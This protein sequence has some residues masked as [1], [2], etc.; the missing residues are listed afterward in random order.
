[1]PG[2]DHKRQRFFHRYRYGLSHLRQHRDGIRHGHRR[3]KAGSK[4]TS[5]RSRRI[6]K[7]QALILTGSALSLIVL[8]IGLSAW[9]SLSNA[10]SSLTKAQALA[11]IVIDKPNMLLSKTGRKRAALDLVDVEDQTNAAQQALD[12]S[13]TLSLLSQLPYLGRQTRGI[14]SLVRDLN[15]SAGGWP[16]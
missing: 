5:H 3:R 14:T 7:R 11:S 15:S 4:P 13:L 10:R 8:V 6:D 2:Y 9:R 12:R 16:R 1:M